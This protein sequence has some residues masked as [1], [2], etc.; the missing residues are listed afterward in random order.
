MNIIVAV[1][2][3]WGIGYHGTQPVVIPED[4]K[5][6]RRI[7]DGGIVVVGRKTLEDFPGGRPLKNRENIIMSTK[8]GFYVEGAQVVS[9]IEML[10]ETISGKDPDKVFVIGGESVYK[11]LVDYCSCAYVT[12]IDSAPQADRFFK[13]LDEDPN[14]EIADPGVWQEYEGIKYCF[15]K[16]INK[17]VRENTK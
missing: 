9:G 12:K 2:S 14:W 4:R 7:T 17:N 16:Y 8:P 10:F 3:N 15:M 5:Y 6:F 13:N 11:Q 1:D